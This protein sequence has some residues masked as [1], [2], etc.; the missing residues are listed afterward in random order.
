MLV[1]RR[2]LTVL[3]A[4]ALGLLGAVA[5]PAA[6]ATIQTLPCNVDTRVTGAKSVPLVGAGFTPGASVTIQTASAAAPTPTFL[7]SAQADAAGNFATTASPPL[8]NK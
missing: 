8:F 7:A 4:A 5:A 2:A 1:P 3:P 6:A